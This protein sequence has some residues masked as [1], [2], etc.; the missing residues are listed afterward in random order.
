MFRT[1]VLICQYHSTHECAH[2]CRHTHAHAHA[3]THTHTPA[4][5]KCLGLLPTENLRSEQ[6][7]SFPQKGKAECLH[8]RAGRDLRPVN[9]A[10]HKLK[11]W[12]GVR[13]QIFSQVGRMGPPICHPG[14]C[15]HFQDAKKSAFKAEPLW[16]W[17]CF[18]LFCSVSRF[19]NLPLSLQGNLRAKF[20]C[21]AN[22][23]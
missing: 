19:L 5:Y 20:T 15:Q 12:A 21:Q 6:R 23:I 2:T 1:L 8:L 18:A 4:T 14:N 11:G 16:C 13:D 7:L 10:L 22:S 3:Q 9:S 17:F